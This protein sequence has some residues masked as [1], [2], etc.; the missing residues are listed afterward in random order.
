MKTT[1]KKAVRITSEQVRR[2]AVAH[3]E[4]H[5][6]EYEEINLTSLGEEIFVHFDMT[7]A[8]YETL[9]VDFLIWHELDRAKLL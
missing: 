3:C 9:D 2:Y 8:E 6:D 4:E 1:L 7:E 5:R